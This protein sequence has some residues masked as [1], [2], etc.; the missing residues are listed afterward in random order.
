VVRGSAEEEHHEADA[1]TDEH[2]QKDGE[3]QDAKLAVSDHPRIPWKKPLPQR[4]H[5]VKL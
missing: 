3:E 4:V 2:A 1:G 5:A